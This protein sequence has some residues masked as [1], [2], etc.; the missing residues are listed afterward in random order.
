M[1]KFENDSIRTRE[2]EVTSN[3]RRSMAANSVASC[4]IGLKFELIQAFMVVHIT[5]RY[6]RRTRAI[7]DDK[8]WNGN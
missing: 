8:I 2:K 3:L 4:E 5:C 1:C 7:T 6:R